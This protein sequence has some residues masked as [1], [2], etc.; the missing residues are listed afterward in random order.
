MKKI[1]KVTVI[2][3]T[4]KR[5]ER[6]EIAINSLVNQTY[7]NLQIIVVDD[8]DSET[9]YRKKTEQI[10]KKYKNNKKID[11]IKHDY[12]KNGAAARNTGIRYSDGEYVCFLDDDDLYY[13]NKIEEQVKFLKKY[14]CFQAVYCWRKQRGKVIKNF[15]EG[16]L[17]K[18]ILL[19]TMTPTMPSLMFKKEALD[20]IDGFNENY[21]RHQDYE[22]LLKFFKK[23][24][25]IGLLKK[26]LVE[27]GTNLGENEIH[28]KNLE[29]LKAIFLNNFS[30]TIEDI[31]KKELNFKKKVLCK[32]HCDIFIDYIKLK[33]IKKII[34]FYISGCRISTI[35][36]NYCFIKR[37]IITLK[38]N[39]REK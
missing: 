16:D 13:S 4:Y 29:N 1:N 38:N 18:E 32:H 24:F 17:S 37:I 20:I 10:M 7:K 26:T 5:P 28:G 31:N 8:N 9:I 36:F 33:K 2:I 34:K 14:N 15:L 35:Y 39:R 21:R 6:L 12:N 27:I 11:Y 30:D 22:L 23:G 25:K 19:G 3:P